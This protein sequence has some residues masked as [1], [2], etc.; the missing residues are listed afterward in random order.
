MIPFRLFVSNE[1]GSDLQNIKAI[2]V[3]TLA[4]MLE[5]DKKI[6]RKKSKVYRNHKPLITEI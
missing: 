4:L 5:A 6:T 1:A 2:F 3:M